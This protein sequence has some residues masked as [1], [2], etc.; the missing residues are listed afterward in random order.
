MMLV[1]KPANNFLNPKTLNSYSE[2]S[3]RRNLQFITIQDDAKAQHF[4]A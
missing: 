3:R 4:F 2:K 1:A